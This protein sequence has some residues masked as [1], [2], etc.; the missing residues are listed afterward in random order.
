MTDVHPTSQPGAIDPA[1]VRSIWDKV[2]RT[3][4]NLA[5]EDIHASLLSIIQ[6]MRLF[7]STPMLKK[8]RQ[9]LTEEIDGLLYRLISDNTF[10]Q[11]FGPVSFPVDREYQ[12]V[13]DFFKNLAEAERGSPKVV[14]DEADTLYKQGQVEEAVQAVQALIP[15]YPLDLDLHQSVG[16]SLLRWERYEDAQAVLEVLLDQHENTVAILNLLAIALKKQKRFQEAIERYKEAL[17]LAPQDEGLYY[18]L[19]VTLAENREL[20]TAKKVLGLALNIRPK[21]PQAQKL[22]ETID[23]ALEKTQGIRRY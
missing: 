10:K 22:L 2:T 16:E 6:A 20:A 14:M 8:D 13:I 4:D 18:N 11:T 15:D 19:A 5:Q 17:K 1:R 7:I 21:F 9:L 23:Q 3:K 12:T